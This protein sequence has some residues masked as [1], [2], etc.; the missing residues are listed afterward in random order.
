MRFTP[1]HRGDLKANGKAK[2]EHLRRQHLHEQLKGL[3]NRP[4]LSSHRYLFETEEDDEVLIV[5]PMGNFGYVPVV[6]SRPS[7]VAAL[8]ITLLRPEPP[9]NIVTQG[10]DLANR[11]TT[12]L[13]APKVPNHPN[14]LPMGAVPAAGES[15]SFCLLEDDNLTPPA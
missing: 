5:R 8:R 14:A 10:G 12:L 1:H 3:W 11:L 7:V 9:G 15:P 4:P 2:D 13:D 6:S